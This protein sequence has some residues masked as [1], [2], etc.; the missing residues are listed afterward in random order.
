[1]SNEAK[2]YWLTRLDYFQTALITIG[3]LMCVFVLV[4]YFWTFLE[5]EDNWDFP[6]KQR[7]YMWIGGVIVLISLFIPSK[8][9]AILIV[10]G[11]KT[12]DFIQQD[13]SINK[14]PSQTTKIISNFLEKQLTKCDTLK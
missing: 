5:M 7:K 9:E 10:A 1:M 2:I 13:S 14:I 12:M 6:K 4:C 8:N 11:G 3:G